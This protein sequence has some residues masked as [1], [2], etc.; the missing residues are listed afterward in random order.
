MLNIY[1]AGAFEDKDRLMQARV[2]LEKKFACFVTSSWLDEPSV[3]KEYASK[4]ATEVIT[5]Q[6]AKFYA[7]RDFRD[8]RESALVIVDTA[9]TNVRGGREVELGYALSR[10]IPAWVV[11]PRRNVFHQLVDQF[12]TWDN[13]YAKIGEMV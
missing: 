6:Q 2:V 7:I 1:I 5:A 9:G 10:G 11:G 8:I 12:E 3:D 4:L 13:V